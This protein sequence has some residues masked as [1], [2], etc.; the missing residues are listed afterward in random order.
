LPDTLDK[1]TSRWLLA[2]LVSGLALR[3]ALVCANYE[4]ILRSGLFGDD[5]FYFLNIARHIA[6][7]HGVTH[8]GINLT[9]GIQPLYTFMLVPLYWACGDNAILPIHLAGVLLALLSVASGWLL[10]LTARR[11]AGDGAGLVALALWM[12]SAYVLR[13]TLNGME[14]GVSAFFTIVSTWWYVMRIRPSEETPAPSAGALLTG[15]ALLGLAILSRM[16]NVVLVAVVV[17][18]HL[19]S[20]RGT[21][22]EGVRRSALF[23]AP[24]AL[25]FGGWLAV[26]LV[27]TGS[28]LPV[29]G[30]AVRLL[31]RVMVAADSE[32]AAGHAAVPALRPVQQ[33]SLKDTWAHTVPMA[34]ETFLNLRQWRFLGD[35]LAGHR[36]VAAAA[37]A[38]AV[39]AILLFL[40]VLRGTGVV[41]ECRHA[42]RRLAPVHWTLVWLALLLAAY[43]LYVFGWWFYPRYLF[44]KAIVMSLFLAVFFD[45]VMLR[46]GLAA[47]EKAR[48]LCWAALG[49]LLAAQ[50]AFGS[51][52]FLLRDNEAFAAY[53]EAALRLNRLP[54][55]K[56]DRV[57][58]FQSGIIGYFARP[59]VIGLDGVVNEGAY[60]ALREGALFD[61]L[62]R[63]RIVALTDTPTI[64]E[65]LCRTDPTYP[66]R[67]ASM[68]LLHH[69]GFDL[70]ALP[71]YRPRQPGARARSEIQPP[72]RNPLP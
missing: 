1:R 56:A 61:Y 66:A 16:D 48:R 40:A 11:L 39:A 44:P 31:S 35:K 58:A 47:R 5:A 3:L 25:A 18:D 17:G 51:A 27:T 30:R 22:R 71:W 7:G 26:N 29:S 55:T 59:T 45:A 21:P 8:D 62:R 37:G 57:G 67:R 6:N 14:T 65:A 54:L 43:S 28:L 32:T 46:S 42:W 68:T 24:A 10:F 34:L 38:L 23:G 13:Q 15:G 70:Y 72:E 50:L 12:F 69:D 63:E 49:S 52:Y 33:A 4:F 64:L 9:N 41:A 53:Y 2:M 36:A 19:V 20:L 60:V